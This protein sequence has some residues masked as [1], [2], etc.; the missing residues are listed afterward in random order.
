[1]FKT[2]NIFHIKLEY[3]ILFLFCGHHTHEGIVNDEEF[4]N[5]KVKQLSRK[6]TNEE[7]MLTDKCI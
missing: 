6:S 4:G 7:K 2:V 3:D 5:K 1:V